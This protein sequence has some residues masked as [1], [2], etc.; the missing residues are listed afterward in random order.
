MLTAA[1]LAF[2]IA[3]GG[4][5]LQGGWTLEG[6]AAAARLTARFSFLWFIA[7]WS[8]SALA[9]LWPGGWR[10][11]L[12]AR[13]RAVGLGFAAA[14]S[15]HFAALLIV[16]LVFHEARSAAALAGGGFGYLMMA[17][18]ALTS[19]DAAVRAM[20]ATAWK[21]LH[22]AGGYVLAGIFAFSYYGRLEDKPWLAVPAL[23]LLAAAAALRVLA[24]AL[25]KRGAA[26]A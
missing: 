9:R 8:S 7:A 15:V 14:H 21:A 25:P 6:A 23:T 12:L 24:W 16:V 10:T 5:G 26:S 11:Q 22:A 19:N 17:A 1:A 18:M 20:G 4:Y 13:R 2:A 3:L